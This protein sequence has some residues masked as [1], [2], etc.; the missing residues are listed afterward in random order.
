MLTVKQG[1]MR[2]PG[3]YLLLG[4]VDGFRAGGI[5]VLKESGFLS[6]PENLLNLFQQRT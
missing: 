1:Y 3:M 2:P 6:W 5:F 4:D